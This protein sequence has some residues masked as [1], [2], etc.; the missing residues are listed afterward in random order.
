M[1][2]FV[3]SI[4]V[5]PIEILLSIT[6]FNCFVMDFFVLVI[7]FLEEFAV[8]FIHGSMKRITLSVI[9]NL[10]DVR[11]WVGI[12]DNE[13]FGHDVKAEARLSKMRDHFDL[14]FAIAMESLV[15]EWYQ[16]SVVAAR[17][18]APPHDDV[19]FIPRCEEARNLDEGCFLCIFIPISL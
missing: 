8:E 10:L 19:R 4:R 12:V 14:V 9:P 17:G 6:E 1:D 2:M 7:Q 11:L 13:P 5:L 18:R 3:T 15:I 16:W